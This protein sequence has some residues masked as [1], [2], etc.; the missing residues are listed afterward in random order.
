MEDKEVEGPSNRFALAQLGLKLVL[1]KRGEYLS[2]YL[3]ARRRERESRR[4]SA[5]GRAAAGA[6]LPLDSLVERIENDD[7]AAELLEEVIETARSSRY[8]AKLAYLGRCLAAALQGNDDAAFDT[9]WMKLAAVKDL[10]SAHVKLLH[11]IRMAERPGSQPRF[12]TGPPGATLFPVSEYALIENPSRGRRGFPASTFHALMAILV[13]NGLVILDQDVDVEI[14]IEL[15][16]D[17]KAAEGSP[18]ATSTTTYRL[19]ALGVDVLDDLLSGK[20]DELD[21]Q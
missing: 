2:D 16:A 7:D 21:S 18:S 1:N 10:E 13:R 14:D 20:P 11:A 4:I 19:S 15:D 6:G 5:V 12:R 9:T 3:E 8:E 17:A